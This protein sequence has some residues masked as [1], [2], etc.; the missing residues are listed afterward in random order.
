MSKV[1]AARSFFDSLCDL[2]TECGSVEGERMREAV[3]GV[4]EALAPGVED[5][6]KGDLV[7]GVAKIVVAHRKRT[8]GAHGQMPEKSKA[9]VLKPF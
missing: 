8:A 7:G 3:D 5:V 2:L 9:G 6:S 1:K 4:G